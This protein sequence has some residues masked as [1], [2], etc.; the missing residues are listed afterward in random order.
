M[1]INIIALLPAIWKVAMLEVREGYHHL[2]APLPVVI[3]RLQRYQHLEAPLAVV[4]LYPSE[5]PPTIYIGMSSV[6]NQL[7]SS[8]DTPLTTI[9][10]SC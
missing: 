3:E 7:Q 4:R 6:H 5:L 9:G 2:E 1:G 10:A 8:G